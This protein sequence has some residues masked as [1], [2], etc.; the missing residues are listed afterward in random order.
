ME[1]CHPFYSYIILNIT[2]DM[3]HAFAVTVLA[4]ERKYSA[5]HYIGLIRLTPGK[6]FLFRNGDARANGRRH[7]NR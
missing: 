7:E 6:N 1:V 4:K 2:S 5:V 3:K